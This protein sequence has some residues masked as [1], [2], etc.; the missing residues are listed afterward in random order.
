MKKRCYPPASSIEI[1]N[2]YAKILKVQD[3]LDHTA[4]RI[5]SINA[6]YQNGQK[7]LLLY[8]KWGCV[9]SSGQSQN[10]QKLPEESEF[11]FDVNLFITSFVPIRLIDEESGAIIWQNPVPSSVRFCRPMLIEFSKETP[12]KTKA[13]VD[14]IKNQ[15]Q[16]LLPSI[17]KASS[18]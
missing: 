9:G 11:I 18:S 1:T 3:L 14:E 8:S 4:A 16:A 2:T 5:L 13:V 7:H 12:E 10:K 17:K 6:V 15:I